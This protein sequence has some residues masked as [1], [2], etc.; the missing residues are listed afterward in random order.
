[1]SQSCLY[2]CCPGCGEVKE[3]TGT[4]EEGDT[5]TC[6]CGAMARAALLNSPDDFVGGR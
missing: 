5:E 6:E 2:W 1:M 3:V 4:V